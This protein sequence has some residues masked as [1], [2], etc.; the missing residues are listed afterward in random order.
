MVKYSHVVIAHTFIKHVVNDL[1]VFTADLYLLINIIMPVVNEENLCKMFYVLLN[2]AMSIKHAIH[3][4][5]Y[6]S[7]SYLHAMFPFLLEHE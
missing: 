7:T 2:N 3:T 1:S 4:V 5:I 6:S